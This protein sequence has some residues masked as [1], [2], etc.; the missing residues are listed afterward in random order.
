MQDGRIFMT[1]FDHN[2]KKPINWCFVEC[3]LDW[4][5]I[6]NKQMRYMNGRQMQFVNWND[7]NYDFENIYYSNAKEAN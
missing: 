4:Y 5:K 7:P 2:N 6:N 3:I 1:M